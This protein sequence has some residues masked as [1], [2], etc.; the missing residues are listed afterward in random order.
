LYEK[1][2]AHPLSVA[3][4]PGVQFV[5][6]APHAASV[7]VI[8]DFN[9]WDPA[10]HPLRARENC[11]I[12]EGFVPGAKPG[13]FYKYCVV[14]RHLGHRVEKADPFGFRSE[15][16]PKNASMVWPLDYKWG[17]GSWMRKR[18][19]RNALDRPMSI[20]EVHAGAWMRVPEE[21]DR[22]LTYRELAV[23]L[24][25]YCREL[26]FTHVE[27]LPIME[28]PFY[29]SW[30][31]QTT[32]YFAPTSRYGSPQD[33]MYLVDYL[34]QQGIGVFLDWVPSHFPT[35]AHSLA[36]FDGTHLF[37]HADPRRGFHP[38]WKSSIFNYGYHEVRSFLL[39]SA[40]FWLDKYHADGLRV[41]AVTSML[42]LNYARKRGEWIPNRYGGHE[43]LEAID[44]LRLLNAT[45]YREYPDTQTIA[46][47]S[48]AWPQVSRP[49]HTGGLGFGLKWDL[50]WM[51]DTLRYLKR[52]WPQR[53]FHHAELPFRV[54][55]AFHENFVLPLSHDLAAAQLPRGRPPR[56]PLEGTVEQRRRGLRR[57]WPGQLRRR[58][59]RAARVA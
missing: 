56:R 21:G 25:A 30:G 13:Q 14:S 26:G 48:S 16:P 27:L 9:R 1:L 24:A 22:W 34:H 20:Y 51:H 17:D 6:W 42:Y 55:Y 15:G 10:R 58:R 45:I 43:N 52:P 40:L 38:E 8:G 19:R 54:I 7:S 5:V 32:G 4:V 33:F 31:Y 28:H 3:G 36:R 44:F 18:A 49:V 53:K 50:G 11:G 35:D 59:G 47:E 2:G 39:S 46:E 29:A 57:R 37:E 41:D 23:K 12:W